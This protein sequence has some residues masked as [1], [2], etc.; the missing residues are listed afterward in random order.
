[1]TESEE[2]VSEIDGLLSEINGLWVS[3]QDYH[4]NSKWTAS[5]YGTSGESIYNPTTKAIDINI[6]AS[7]GLAGL[8]HELTHGA[9]FERGLTDFKLN[10][11]GR[12][13]LHDITDEQSSFRR[14]FAINS[15]SVGLNHIG[16]LQ[17]VGLED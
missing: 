11:T 6:T 15:S 16:K 10:G 17:I 13:F 3:A 12:G 7:Y 1:M 4:V 9:Q 2:I 8:A 14:Q 5:S